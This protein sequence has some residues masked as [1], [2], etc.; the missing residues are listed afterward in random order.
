[1]QLVISA[2]KSSYTTPIPS[3]TPFQSELKDSYESHVDINN[4]P[5]LSHEFK[6]ESN[7]TMSYLREPSSENNVFQN[8]GEI[9]ILC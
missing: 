8:E 7:S 6:S 9:L 3:S 2:M 5:P 1:M 4:H